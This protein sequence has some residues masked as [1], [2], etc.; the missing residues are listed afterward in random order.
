MYACM[1][2]CVSMYVCL[3]VCVCVCV[4]T[5]GHSRTL[6]HTHALTSSPDL[7]ANSH[8]CF[9]LST[10]RCQMDCHLAERE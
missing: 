8:V 5:H 1:Y 7:A 6:T 4:Q 10:N 3:C 2:M 9:V